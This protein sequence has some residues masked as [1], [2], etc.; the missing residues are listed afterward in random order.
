MVRITLIL[1]AMM[2]FLACKPAQQLSTVKDVD[3]NR[4]TGLWYEIARLPNSFEKGL[5]C[6]TATYTFKK[7]GKIEVLNKGYLIKEAGKSKTA[8][9]TAWVPNVEFPGRLKVTFF[10]PFAGDYYMISLDEAYKYV[11][12]GDPSRKYL[13]VLSRD[14]DLDNT[15][16]AELLNIART[17]GF[18]TDN[19]IKV[20]QDCH[21]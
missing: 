18:D 20:N 15:V 14:K 16:Y 4:Y 21:Q 6:T 5:E 7:N 10:W 2:S 3:L 12:V 17:N 11:L 8:R 1:F 9:G 19:I 13:W